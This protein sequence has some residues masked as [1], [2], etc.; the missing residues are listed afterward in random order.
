MKLALHPVTHV[1]IRRERFDNTEE[2]QKG[3]LRESKEE[4]LELCC[5]KPRNAKDCQQ[6]P[7]AGRG[8]EA[9][10]PGAFG[11]SMVLPMP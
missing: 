2:T 6:P 4:R 10:F 9:F 3:R 7:E 5:H 1:L 8:K 11:G